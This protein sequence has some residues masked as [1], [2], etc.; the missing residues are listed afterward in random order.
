MALIPRINIKYLS[1][2]GTGFFGI[3][4]IQIY[5]SN[6]GQFANGNGIAVTYQQTINSYIDSYTVYISGESLSIY[7]GKLDDSDPLNPYYT[8]FKIT[9]FNTSP[10]PDT[11]PEPAAPNCDLAI[12]K[13][14]INQ[15]E[16]APGAN[17]ARITVQATS[18][19]G[20]ITYSLDDDNYQS[21]ATFTGLSAGFITVYAKD[22][23]GCKT[24]TY[25]TVPV[26]KN[27]LLSGPSVTLHGNTSR[28][29]A[30]FNPVIFTYQRKD[31]SISAAALD[32]VTQKVRLTVNTNVSTVVS[33]DMVYVETNKYTG[34]YKVLGNN[35][36]TGLIIDAA[37]TG[38]ATGFININRLRPYY[39][40][41]TKITFTDKIIGIQSSIT[42]TNRP[43]GKG[44]TRA[45]ISNFLQSL[46][47]AADA[48]DY[49][50]P[51]YNDSNLCAGYTIA[52]AEQWDEGG[53][54]QTSGFVN[55]P[56]PYYVVYAARQLGQANGG[57]LLEYVPFL[58]TVTGTPKAKWLSD[59]TEPAYS[60][61]YP[62][63]IGF[64]YSDELDG[65]NVYCEI[66]PLDI[67][68]KP[69]ALPAGD[70]HYLNNSGSWL[71][72]EDG[73]KLVLARNT[74]QNLPIS[75]SAGLNRMLIDTSFG[76]E[77]YFINITL[78]Y[79]DGGTVRAITQTQTIR[80]DDAIDDQSVYLRWVGLTGSWNY[81][82]FVFN[83]EV[84]LDVQNATII[85][86]YVLDWENQEGIEEVIS[87]T[88]GQKMKVIAED[89][90]VADIKGLQSIKYSPKVQ[91]M[92]NKNPVKWQTIVINTATYS[93]Y[94]TR[95]GRAP[96]SVTFN[97]PAIN[98]QGQ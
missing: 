83:Q 72:S 63:D 20:P 25:V 82:R 5:D 34:T 84:S 3:V 14:T 28:W 27:L 12:Q 44:I 97:L 66:V 55:I 1:T 91:I 89:L 64:I 16:S 90:S 36:S 56:D 6:T 40:V 15:A 78:K 81:Y 13:V 4:S 86:S 68:R 23:D 35:G 58:T 8:D 77:V 69:L 2:T 70:S 18:S 67:N 10:P 88:A 52:Y 92:V 19:N 33:G 71:L 38:T 50:Q 43:D 57:N 17:N 29:N 75:G 85:K 7:N 31:F 9:G 87:K 80:V 65:N 94:E 30:A 62:F 79:N 95:N 96:F 24:Q 39:S 45:D 60:N 98:V 74:I 26:V 59:F 46:L 32:S 47:R 37:Y 51:Y 61:G 22:G 93:E 41:A 76:D 53:E 73:S 11:N 48:S 54:T 42:A 21:S 49:T